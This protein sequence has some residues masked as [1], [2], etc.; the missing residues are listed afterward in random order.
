MNSAVREMTLAGLG[1]QYP[2]DS[3]DQHRQRLA[4]SLFGPDIAHHLYERQGGILAMQSSLIEVMTAVADTFDRFEIVYVIGGS[5]ASAYYGVGRSTLDV[6]FVADVRPEHILAL[7]DSLSH[8]FYLDEQAIQTAIERRSSF[9]LIHL[10]T[11]FKVDVF[12]PGVRDFDRLQLNRR[13]TAAIGP[14]GEQQV[15]LLTAEDVVLA[16]LDWYRLGGE[17][18]DRQWRDILGV[19]LSQ[20]SRLDVDYLRVNADGLGVSDLLERAFRESDFS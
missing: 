10:A 16:K 18:S 15:Y 7:A 9:N 20:K 6:D 8:D 11:M 12:I 17:L 3:P 4:D 1:R 14:E 13:I 2:Q 19:L 5:M